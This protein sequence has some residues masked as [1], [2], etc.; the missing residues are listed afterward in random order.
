[1]FK[2]TGQRMSH[3]AARRRLRTRLRSE[4]DPPTHPVSSGCFVFLPWTSNSSLNRL[5]LVLDLFLLQ[6]SGV[7]LGVGAAGHLALRVLTR[8]LFGW[9]GTGGRGDGDGRSGGCSGRRRAGARTDRTAA[10]DAALGR[11]ETRRQWQRLGHAQQ[12][13]DLA[14][15][16]QSQRFL[17]TKRQH[18]PAS[19]AV[20]FFL[21][22]L[23][24]SNSLLSASM[25]GEQ[26]QY[27]RPS[28]RR[29][30]SF[31]LR[32]TSSNVITRFRGFVSIEM[33]HNVH[34]SFI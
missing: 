30:D 16:N 4:P 17:W 19:V 28:C 5:V 14:E 1:M 31:S 20:A 34:I 32:R 7:H 10:A 12:F 29:F 6:I 22:A 13:E 23:P 9:T 26:K 24:L 25:A 2:S 27:R 11:S 33:F 15:G 3:E 18:P 8:P 21:K